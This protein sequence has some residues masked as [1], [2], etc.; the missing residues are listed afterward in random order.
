MATWVLISS[1]I[2]MTQLFP[3]FLINMKF[4]F[5]PHGIGGLD[6][7]VKTAAGN[8]AAVVL[9]FCEKPETL[10]VCHVPLHQGSGQGNTEKGS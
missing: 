6:V 7:G 1:S 2:I 10:M 4:K 3:R 5:E 9:V 8:L